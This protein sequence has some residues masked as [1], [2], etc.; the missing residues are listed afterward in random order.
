[1]EAN[2]IQIGDHEGII[3][4]TDILRKLNLSIKDAV[5]MHLVDRRIVIE[6]YPRKGW[7]EAARRAHARGDDKLFFNDAINEE[8]VP[9]WTW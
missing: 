7:A 3:L 1:M 6:A 9:E 2:I 5:K 4:P 8:T